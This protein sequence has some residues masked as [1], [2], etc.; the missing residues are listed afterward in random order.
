MTIGCSS[1]GEDAQIPMLRVSRRNKGVNPGTALL[2]QIFRNRLPGSDEETI[3]LGSRGDVTAMV[4]CAHLLGD[5]LRDGDAAARV[6]RATLAG[7]VINVAAFPENCLAVIL[8]GAGGRS[9][10]LV[11][12]HHV[13]RNERLLWREQRHDSMVVNPV[14]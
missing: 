1:M 12:I 13:G 6:D 14:P 5:R 8:G 11:E 2:R 4:G 7:V 9:V 10:V 3:V